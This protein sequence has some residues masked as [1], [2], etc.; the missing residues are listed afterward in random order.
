[1]LLRSRPATGASSPRGHGGRASSPSGPES[2]L[3]GFSEELR[4]C[5]QVVGAEQDG[6]LDAHGLAAHRGELRDEVL[7]VGV[8][9]ERG[10]YPAC[11]SSEAEPAPNGLPRAPAPVARAK[12][13][14]PGADNPAPA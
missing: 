4:W 2:V 3:H 5:L 13:A 6:V 8:V 10:R 11:A 14:A 12:P 1:M 7:G 9:R